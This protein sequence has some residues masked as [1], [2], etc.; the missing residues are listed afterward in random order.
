MSSVY[1]LSLDNEVILGVEIL[2]RIG[3]PVLPD[4]CTDFLLHRVCSQSAPPCNRETGL[5][6]AFCEDDCRLYEQ[7]RGRG[8]CNEVDGR[9]TNLRETTSSPV[10]DVLADAYFNFSCS[11]PATYYRMNPLST[12]PNFCTGLF[13]PQ[14]KGM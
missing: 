10:F 9:I 4:E 7:L 14:V 2:A 12:D 6:M 11:D 1:D 5:L 3:D 13:S 8:I